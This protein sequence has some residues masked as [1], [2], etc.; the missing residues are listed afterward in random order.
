MF[1]GPNSPRPSQAQQLPWVAP[2]DMD[3]WFDAL[4]P[5]EPSA[6]DRLAALVDEGARERVQ[7]AEDLVRHWDETQEQV[8]Q[9]QEFTRQVDRYREYAQMD[10]QPLIQGAGY[11]DYVITRSSQTS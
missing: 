10:E 7:K 1:G 5:P 6:V 8:K 9:V 4:R 2:T 3:N 11:T